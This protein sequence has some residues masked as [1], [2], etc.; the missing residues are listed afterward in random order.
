MTQ[1]LA[2]LNANQPVA[3]TEQGG[4]GGKSAGAATLGELLQRM[5][6]LLSLPDEAARVVGTTG[7][8]LP[9]AGPGGGQGAG[10]LAVP[11]CAEEPGVPR[12]GQLRGT[13]RKAP[14]AQPSRRGCQQPESPAGAEPSCK[15]QRSMEPPQV[16]PHSYITG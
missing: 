5:L 2:Y 7:T 4:G 6:H 9:A 12:A 10:L 3:E 8:D 1:L 11:A 16:R 13:K 15:R 14:G